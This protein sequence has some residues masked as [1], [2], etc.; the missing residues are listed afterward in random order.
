ML[1]S[2]LDIFFPPVCP[3]CEEALVDT[4]TNI[5]PNGSMDASTI[6]TPAPP[7]LTNLCRDCIDGFLKLRI[8]IPYC[9]VC[10]IPFNAPSNG[11]HP[12]GECIKSPPPFETARSGFAYSGTVL[13]AIHL[14]KY[15]G[16]TTLSLPLGKFAANA[17]ESAL[18][19]D[20]VVPVPL[21]IKRLRQRGYNHSLLFARHV[22]QRLSVPVDTTALKRTRPTVPQ[23]ELSA[24]LRQT[25]VAG[26][27]EVVKPDTVR[28][29]RVLLVDDVLTTGATVRECARVL[30]KAGASV[31]V[32]TLARTIK[33]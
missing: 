19:V 3:L 24:S 1:G 17:V 20:L 13:D 16:R 4:S 30:R 14:L 9:S 28:D 22:A 7:H 32:L 27:F 2:I 31:H 18:T 33:V 26:A 6:D 29:R 10:G 12:C 15:N 5:E 23:V 8:N 25:N 21:H 11:V